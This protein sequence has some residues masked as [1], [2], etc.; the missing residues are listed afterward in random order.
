[1]DVLR[2]IAGKHVTEHVTQ[3]AATTEDDYT[4]SVG[5]LT[6]EG[7]VYVPDSPGL[8]AIVTALHHDTPESGRFGALKTAELVRESG[9][10]L[11][12]EFSLLNLY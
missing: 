10:P 4:V 11:I 7:R 2:K 8:R 3:D 12:N 1:M 6:H 9:I 5:A